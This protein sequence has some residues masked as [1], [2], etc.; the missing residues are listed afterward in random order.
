MGISRVYGGLLARA[1][2]KGVEFG[3]VATIGRQ[4]LCI[5]PED[6]AELG[7]RLGRTGLDWPRISSAGYAEPFLKEVLG[8]NHVTSF[9]YSDYQG[10]DITHD[11]NQPLAANLHQ[12]FDSLVDGGT[13]EHIF[14]V[15]CVLANYMSMV[16]CGGSIFVHTPANNLMGHGFYQFC[17][18]LFYRVFSAENGFSVE[19]VCLTESPFP[20]IEISRRQRGYLARDPESMGKRI[21]FVND[22]PLMIFVHARRTEVK[23][24]FQ[25]APAQS[26]LALVWAAHETE[27]TEGEPGMKQEGPELTAR[28]FR[29][30][31]WWEEVRRWHVLRRKKSFRNKRFFQPLDV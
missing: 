16:K 24:L 26:D 20:S 2:Q 29:Y 7:K 21:R 13:M 19:E 14:D 15:K 8:A 9:D 22:R 11:F 27:K 31:S 28:P 1:R 12:T 17:P 18:E 10:V 6:L 4:S 30:I 23:P 25:S 3:H 5:P